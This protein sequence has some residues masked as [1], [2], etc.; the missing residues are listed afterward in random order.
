M[1]RALTDLRIYRP[2]DKVKGPPFSHGCFDPRRPLASILH[3][4]GRDSHCFALW[5]LW[6]F[7]RYPNF[8]TCSSCFPHAQMPEL[9]PRPSRSR[10]SSSVFCLLVTSSHISASWRKL[11]LSASSWTFYLLPRWLL[12]LHRFPATPRS[13]LWPLVSSSAHL[14]RVFWGLPDLAKTSS[15][16]GCCCFFSKFCIMWTVFRW[17]ACR[18]HA[19]S[20]FPIFFLSFPFDSVHRHTLSRSLFQ[21]PCSQTHMW[22]TPHTWHFFWG[23]KVGLKSHSI[24]SS[25]AQLPCLS[26]TVAT[27]TT[28]LLHRT[29]VVP[30][31]LGTNSRF[32]FGTATLHRPSAGCESNANDSTNANVWIKNDEQWDGFERRQCFFQ[33]WVWRSRHKI[34]TCPSHCSFPQVQI[35]RRTIL[36]WSRSHKL[37][38]TPCTM[39]TVSNRYQTRQEWILG[40][41]SV[42]L[43][44]LKVY[45]QFLDLK[46]PFKGLR[47]EPEK[48]CMIRA[49]RLDVLYSVNGNS[50]L[51][52]IRKKA[53]AREDFVKILAG[54]HK[55]T[56]LPRADA[57]SGSSNT[58]QTHDCPKDKGNV[59]AILSSGKSS[60]WQSARSCEGTSEVRE[61]RRASIRFT[62]RTQ[63]SD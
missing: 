45:L 16:F 61:T 20:V 22:R 57:S 27:S 33:L 60:S 30:L 4:H 49:K 53:A 51:P 43:D 50:L 3:S 41:C 62:F 46:K 36:H 37:E 10:C 28:T 55:S 25:D 39:F 8:C 38:A 9:E 12:P 54:H 44:I 2:N 29:S 1:W 6:V 5:G 59:L 31:H 11:L 35:C 56:Q 58:K 47:N 17:S 52:V 63:S 14:P 48:L 40:N 26:A 7:R 19:R 21:R 24:R 13:H 18:F 42:P 32:V 34:H 23:F 15:F